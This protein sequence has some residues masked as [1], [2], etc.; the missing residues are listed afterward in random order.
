MTGLAEQLQAM[1]DLDALLD[2]WATPNPEGT[3][4]TTVR[5]WRHLCGTELIDAQLVARWF[6]LAD[7]T[8]GGWAVMPCDL[9]PSSGVSPVAAVP[10]ER[11][12][13][14]IAELHNAALDA[15]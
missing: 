7:D 2:D 10:S 1:L 6:A 12:A 13:R 15:L 14:H 5:Y 11:V 4:V 8:I 3:A 9:P